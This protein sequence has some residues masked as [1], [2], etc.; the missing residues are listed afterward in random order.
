MK[1]RMT[2]DQYADYAAYLFP[3]WSVTMLDKWIKAKMRCDS[4]TWAFPVSSGA[5]PSVMEHDFFRTLPPGP[6]LMIVPDLRDKVRSN[7]RYLAGMF[8]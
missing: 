8:A 4:G 1:Q 5:L 6:P 3:H 7:V 2:T